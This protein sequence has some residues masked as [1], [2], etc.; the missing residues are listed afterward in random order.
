MKFHTR[1]NLKLPASEIRIVLPR[2][3]QRSLRLTRIAHLSSVAQKSTPT[4]ARSHRNPQ[5]PDSIRVIHRVHPRPH[6]N[7]QYARH[8]RAVPTRAPGQTTIQSAN[9]QQRY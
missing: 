1:A 3:C 2:N 7:A 9:Q 6:F 4:A 8:T 5:H